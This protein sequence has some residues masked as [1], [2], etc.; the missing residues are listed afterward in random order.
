MQPPVLFQ[1]LWLAV[2]HMTSN[3][4]NY[5]WVITWIWVEFGNTCN[6]MKFCLLNNHSNSWHSLREVPLCMPKSHTLYF[7]THARYNH[8][9]DTWGP[10]WFVCYSEACRVIGLGTSLGLRLHSRDAALKLSPQF[11]WGE[12]NSSR[13][14]WSRKYSTLVAMHGIQ[15]N[16]YQLT[17]CS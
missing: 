8:Q 3:N 1:G 2:G 13:G 16:L 4:N 6:C 15:K 12:K 9:S 7:S 10:G 17:F 5:V 11:V 14:F